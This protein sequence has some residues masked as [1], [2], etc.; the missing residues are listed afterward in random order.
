MLIIGASATAVVVVAAGVGIWFYMNQ[1]KTVN[2]N[3]VAL[4]QYKEETVRVDDII[5][6]VSELGS[7]SMNTENVSVGYDVTVLEVYAKAGAYV[8]EGDVLVM[9]DASLQEEQIELL[10]SELE[11][12]ILTLEATL[13]DAESRKLKALQTYQTTLVVGQYAESNYNLDMEDLDE[14][15]SSM[16][17][18]ITTLDTEIALAE[19]DI[20]NLEE[21][22][23][24]SSLESS[25]SSK[26]SALSSLQS[27]LATVQAD[28]DAAEEALKDAT[29]EE[30]DYDEIVEEEEEAKTELEELQSE[31]STAS[32]SLSEAESK[33]SQAYESVESEE[34]RLLSEIDSANDSKESV[35]SNIWDYATD[36]TLNRLQVSSTYDTSMY[37]YGV[38]EQVYNNTLAQIDN[39]VSTAQ[40]KVADLEE[41]IA[42]YDGITNMI[43]APCA[44]Y[45][46][47]QTEAG[48]EVNANGTITTLAGNTSVDILVSIDQEDIADLSVGMET[49][50]VFD[51]YEDQ[52]M[53]GVID[54]ISIVPSG[55]M[56]SSVSYTVTVACDL[57]NYDNIVIYESMTATVTFI[58]KQTKDVL[59][60]SS[61]CVTNESGKQYV[62]VINELGVVEQVEITTG[63]SDGFDVEVTSGLEE[64][65]I[66]ILESAVM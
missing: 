63:F 8:E 56:Q 15:L 65:D 39:E 47:S 36:E 24:I 21:K 29:G 33:L 1:A 61:K 30:E 60:I 52:P 57:T 34:E 42:E 11:L 19:I 53:D 10:K 59:V 3:S 17:S 16:E 20:S 31:I 23:E 25:V 46:M 13:L 7:A 4:N 18:S 32:Q 50:V 38:A 22:Y 66:V 44:G 28:Y 26:T 49:S 45:V 54:S 51:A 64:G 37:E 62:K 41:E 27:Q 58:Q 35:T 2:G 12:E 43:T 5:V 40:D 55:G 48:A 6:G 14:Q 9:I